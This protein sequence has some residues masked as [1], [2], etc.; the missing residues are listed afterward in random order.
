M[1]ELKKTHLHDFHARNAHMFEFA[2]FEMPLWYEGIVSE[3]LAVR[4]S[5][6]VFDISHMG[7]C[8]VEG[9]E[10]A[11]LLDYVL[12]RDIVSLNVGQ[13]R[14]S[15]MCNE[16]G[17]IVDDLVVFRLSEDRFVVVYNATNREKDFNWL[18][19]HSRK[20]DAK[21]NDV[22]DDVAMFAVQGPK[23]VETVISIAKADITNIRYYWGTWN[24]LGESDV[25]LTRTGYTGEDGFEML[26]WGVSPK[27][28]T[29]AE[30]LWQT[31]VDAGVR[32]NLKPCG[33]GARDSLRLEAGMCLYGNELDEVTTPFEAG[34]DF[35][36]QLEKR[37]FVGKEDLIK[38]KEKSVPR[39]RVGILSKDGRIPR[40]RDALF[41][42]EKE[43][44]HVTSGTFSPLLK[45]G[46]GMGY[47]STE[48]S[49][50]GITL[51]VKSQRAIFPTEIVKM[52]FY[53]ETK[54]GRRRLQT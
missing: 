8:I 5:V 45:R 54:Y 46:I 30:R 29:E 7:R 9:K 39:V 47:V 13:G 14:Y 26:F 11:Q 28:S 17:G 23:A 38:Q 53:D 4:N 10:A 48:Y 19:L 18:R 32:Y 15:V 35:V 21:L 40:P 49:N 33:L 12:T 31:I 37:E 27:R 36:V 52:P 16:S 20:F 41:S 50:I 6:G 22:S 1:S 3:H 24:R 44:G 42:G 2:G 43:I 51:N 25:F 34:L